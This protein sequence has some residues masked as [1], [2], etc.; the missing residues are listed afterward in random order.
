MKCYNKIIIIGYVGGEPTVRYTSN[1][2]TVAEFSVA[3]NEKYKKDGEY[4]T[5][6]TWFSCTVWGKTVNYV[7]EY[8]GKGQ[9]LLVEGSVRED[10]WVDAT[11]QRKQRYYI[12][13]SAVRPLT[14]I[15]S[16]TPK[17]DVV[18]EQQ[19]DVMTTE[20]TPVKAF[21]F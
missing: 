8:V 7:K 4:R 6:T 9:L 10:N 13:C 12:N 21:P 2:L 18:E 5:N 15:D 17:N 16:Q 19:E 1:G 14:F 3:V 11:G 20:N